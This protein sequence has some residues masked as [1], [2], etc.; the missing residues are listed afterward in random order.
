MASRKA[1]ADLGGWCFD[2]WYLDGGQV[3][4]P[5]KYAGAFLRAFDERLIAAGGIRVAPGEF[6]SV[7]RPLSDSA[8]DDVSTWATRHIIETC[9]LQL[10]GEPNIKV[11]GIELGTG[12]MQKQLLEH[13]EKVIQLCAALCGL[14]DVRAELSLLRVSANTSNIAHLLCAAGPNLPAETLADFD[15]MQKAVLSD[16][17]GANVS[18]HMWC[19]ATTTAASGGLGMRQAAECSSHFSLPAERRPGDWR[20]MLLAPSRLKL[21]QSLGRRCTSGCL[22]LGAKHWVPTWQC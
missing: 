19:Q 9:K 10:Q 15:R 20:R 12:A 18:E 22:H 3:V 8:S 1:V 7:A 11:L 2:C 16:T 6:K 14:E 21:F 13:V 5:A 4:L 17:L